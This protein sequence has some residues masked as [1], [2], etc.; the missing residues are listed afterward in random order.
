[1][2]Y[3]T[4]PPF[5]FIYPI[6]LDVF[7]MSIRTFQIQTEPTVVEKKPVSFK[8]KLKIQNS[9]FFRSFSFEKS[10]F[11]SWSDIYWFG[12]AYRNSIHIVTLVRA[13][14]IYLRH[15]I[16]WYFYNVF[17]VVA[18]ILKYWFF[19]FNLNHQNNCLKRSNESYLLKKNLLQYSRNRR[20]RIFTKQNA[21]KSIYN[22][23]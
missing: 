5:H 1:L 21:S 7:P 11:A 19:L 17:F 23:F 14:N 13:N 16:K 6:S 9:F 4:F 22:L 3:A 18:L 20:L 8:N 10:S 12:L 15:T 2:D